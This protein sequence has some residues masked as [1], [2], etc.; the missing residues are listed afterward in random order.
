MHN[1]GW[2]NLAVSAQHGKV[3]F[4][5]HNHGCRLMLVVHL[6]DVIIILRHVY[7]HET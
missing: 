1:S 6:T 3:Q 5:A 2:F 7:C 4:V